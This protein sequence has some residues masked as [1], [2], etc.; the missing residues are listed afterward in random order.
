MTLYL[1]KTISE[2]AIRDRDVNAKTYQMIAY[3]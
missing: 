1:D 3:V 2:L